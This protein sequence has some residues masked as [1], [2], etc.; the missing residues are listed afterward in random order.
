[1]QPENVVM[2]NIDLLVPNPNQPRKTFNEFA[3]KELSMSIKEYGILNPILAIKKDDKYEIIAG[4]RRYRAAKQIGLTEVPVI[5]KNISEEKISELALIENLQRENITQI[6]EAKTFQEILQNKSITEEKLSEMI[7]K[8]QPYISNKIRLLKLP[9]SIQKA[10]N[11]KKISERHARS[12]LTVDNI[13]EQE[14]LLAKII[15]EK[16]SVK[17]LENIIKNRKE[18]KESDNMNNGNFFP[19]YNNNEQNNNMSLNTM[20]MQTMNTP[21]Q[22]PA[23]AQEPVIAPQVPVEPIINSAPMPSEPVAPLPQVEI[24]NMDTPT[25]A[26]ETPTVPNL[27]EGISPIPEF[28]VNAP[29][30][31]VSQSVEPAPA[32]E[33]VIAPQAPVEPVL[34]KM[35]SVLPQVE[36]NEMAPEPV[37]PTEPPV[38][39]PLEDQ[40]PVIPPAAPPVMD[41]PLFNAELNNPTPAPTPEPNLN[42]AFYDV[43]VNVSPVIETPQEDKVT[44]VEQLLSSNN[45]EY[46]SYSNET[47][48]CI[49]IEL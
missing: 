33:P 5:V 27:T 4:E 48:H 13:D 20:N 15:A 30:N 19:N 17:E 24:Q 39:P 46:K 14:E 38:A 31:E 34:P 45:I 10:V 22:E 41:A 11:D 37:A 35:D 8:S 9:E 29:L 28:G 43:P 1:M 12:L 7:G 49:I 2:L 18:E 44:Q 40:Q 32:I 23:P 25:P 42:E 47:G 26:Q 3:L 16:L 6:E 21:T 36:I